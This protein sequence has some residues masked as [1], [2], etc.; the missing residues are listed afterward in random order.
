MLFPLKVDG[1]QSV[2]NA[3]GDR[4]DVSSETVWRIIAV[5]ALLLIIP[6]V[7]FRV[8]KWMR[9]RDVQARRFDQLQKI[10]DQQGLD[11]IEQSTVERLVLAVPKANP[12]QVVT[13]VDGFDQAILQ[14][15]KVVRRLP[16]L[17]MEQEVERIAAVREKLGFRYIPVDRHPSNTRHLR[18]GQC[19]YILA[20]G[21]EHFRLL[22]APIINLNDLAIH[23]EQFREGDQTV[24]LKAQNKV[25][26]FFWSPAGGECRFSTRLIKEYASPA[27]YLLFEHADDLVYND[28]RKIFSCDLDVSVTVERVSAESYGRAKPSDS[29]FEKHEVDCLPAQIL[30][31]S[32]SGFVVSPAEAFKLNDLVRLRVTDSDLDFIDGWPAL[33]VSEDE[34]QARCRFL[35]KSRERLET[36]LRYVTPRISKNAL[37]GRSRKRAVTHTP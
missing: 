33:V 30:E 14:R 4:E 27:P 7:A 13:S 26:A 20:R 17:E 16:W 12:T 5:F 22:S 31:L 37:K 6:V 36:I 32:A 24:R 11:P 8:R 18:V 1:Y 3:L 19:I 23:T 28:D 21:T 34:P 29:L 9:R 15:M 35:E 2:L 10:C 25:W